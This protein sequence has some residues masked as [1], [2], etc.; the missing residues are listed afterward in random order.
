MLNQTL[1]ICLSCLILFV[2]NGVFMLCYFYV[3]D[4]YGELCVLLREVK[5]H[6][7]QKGK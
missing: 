1:F 3:I 6:E 2:L 4:L 7:L 5:H